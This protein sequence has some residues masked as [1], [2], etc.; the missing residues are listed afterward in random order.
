[1][2]EAC[3]IRNARMTRHEICFLRQSSAMHWFYALKTKMNMEQTFMEVL[4]CHINVLFLQ[5][6]KWSGYIYSKNIHSTHESD[7]YIT[8]KDSW[9]KDFC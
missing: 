8:V 7:V 4:N 5:S 6:N 3:H 2:K 1:M 9:S